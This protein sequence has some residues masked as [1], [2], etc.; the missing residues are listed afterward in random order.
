MQIC[1]TTN[2]EP[3]MGK[4]I[5]TVGILHK[6]EMRNTE[7]EASNKTTAFMTTNQTEKQVLERKYSRLQHF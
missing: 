4:G 2:G 3:L 1:G 5:L 7:K 6:K